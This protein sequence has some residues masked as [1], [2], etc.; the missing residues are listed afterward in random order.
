MGSAARAGP[1]RP[2]I[3]A[4][5]RRRFMRVSSSYE[6]VPRTASILESTRSV[7]KYLKHDVSISVTYASGLFQRRVVRI[8]LGA[9]AVEGLLLRRSPGQ[10]IADA[11]DEVGVGDEGPAD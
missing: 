6:V 3:K 9:T 5:A 8:A 1:A 11:R 7:V 10:V 2:A 4:S